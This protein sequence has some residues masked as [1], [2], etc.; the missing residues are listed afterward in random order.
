MEEFALVEADFQQYYQLDLETYCTDVLNK[1]RGFLRY[2]RL[3][4]NLPSKSRIMLKLAP[5]GGWSWR[6]ETMSRILTELSAIKAITFNSNR[7]KSQKPM[8]PDEQFQPEE[9]KVAKDEYVEW[10]KEQKNQPEDADATR[11]F[12]QARNPDVK[13]L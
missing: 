12:W 7:T 13:I 11:A 5:A 10:Q 1:G 9:V 2:V 3:F 6:D 4:A 8:K